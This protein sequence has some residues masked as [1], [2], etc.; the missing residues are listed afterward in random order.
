MCSVLQSTWSAHT[1]STTKN[2][3]RKGL[4]ATIFTTTVL[5]KRVKIITAT[6]EHITGIPRTQ[7]LVA[8]YKSTHTRTRTRLRATPWEC[9]TGGVMKSESPSMQVQ[10]IHSLIRAPGAIYSLRWGISWR[11]LSAKHPVGKVG[12]CEASE[13]RRT[14]PYSGFDAAIGNLYESSAFLCTVSNVL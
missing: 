1:T 14:L 12:V 2:Y 10:R 4:P 3:T 13:T 9:L 7:T 11:A 5:T 8:L 6:E